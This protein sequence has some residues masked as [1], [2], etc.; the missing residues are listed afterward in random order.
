MKQVVSVSG[1]KDSTAT[2]CM[3]VE[4]GLPFEAVFADTGNEHPATY[5]AVRQLAAK[6]GGPEPR[7]VKA[8]FT[9]RILGK[10]AFIEKHW[11]KQG[12]PVELKERALAALV[13]TG[14]PFL[15]LCLW[16]GLF[17]SRKAQFC[18]VEL[19]VLPINNQVTKPYLLA[20]ETLVSWQGVRRAESF[21][22]S[23]LPGL[24]R[25]NEE[26]VAG[27]KVAGRYYVY[28]PLIDI[29]SVDDV[30]AIGRRHGIEPNPLYAA[31]C[32]RV[33]CFPCVNAGKDELR[34]ASHWFPEQIDRIAEWER[35]VSEACRRGFATFFA[36]VNDPVMRGAYEDLVLIHGGDAVASKMSAEGF[37]I[38]QMVQWAKT[39]R[40]GRQFNLFYA[41]EGTVCSTHGMCE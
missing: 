36:V 21:E 9:D 10:R 32:S 20:G 31:G 24:Q 3:A 11:E 4:R 14:I 37:G 18:T 28:R 8:D 33:G 22:R 2:Y 7:W 29:T 25:M 27:C 35:L 15:D 34:V 41:P 40:G 26:E 12:V 19:K 39:D 13:P 38:R 16:K 5:E 6:T 17:P 1:G 30:F 23:L